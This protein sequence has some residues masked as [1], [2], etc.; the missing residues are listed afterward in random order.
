MKTVVAAAKAGAQI[1]ALCNLGDEQIAQRTDKVYNKGKVE[2]GLAFPTCVSVNNVVGHFSPL[3]EDTTVLQA[4]DVVKIALGAHVDGY[5]AQVAHTLVVREAGDDKP[6]TG[7]AANVVSAAHNAAE[8]AIRLLKAGNTNQ[9]ITEAISKVASAFHC[10]PIEGVLS[11]SIKRFTLDG[12]KV[13]MNQLDADNTVEEVTFESGEAYTIDIMMSTGSGA[14]REG[15]QRTTVYVRNAD[16]AYGLKLKA[17]RFLYSEITRR[18]PALPFSLRALDEDRRGRLGIV[19][20]AK[21]DLARGFPV[22]V[23]KPG[24]LVAHVQFTAIITASGTHRLTSHPADLVQP[25]HAIEDADLKALLATAAAPKKKKA[26]S[27][28]NKEEGDKE[29]AAAAE[30]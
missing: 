18:F 15:E 1:V 16:A 21:N 26:A 6:A 27:K 19:E 29:G 28:K 7:R 13:I 30:N 8:A 22:L 25:D 17:S 23:E 3:A 11:H 5:I 14:T 24:E 20:V 10:A 2:K 4:G 12:D 9:Q